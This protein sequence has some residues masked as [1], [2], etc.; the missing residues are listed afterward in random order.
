MVLLA[1]I[2]LIFTTKV[3]KYWLGLSSV[4]VNCVNSANEFVEQFKGLAIPIYTSSAST[5]DV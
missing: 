3:G 2:Q 5:E 1:H 4:K